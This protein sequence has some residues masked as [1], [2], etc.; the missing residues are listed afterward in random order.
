MALG[1]VAVVKA[2][3][4]CAQPGAALHLVVAA[5]NKATHLASHHHLPLRVGNELFGIIQMNK[6]QESESLAR[7]VWAT[8]R[9][10]ASGILQVVGPSLQK[11]LE[12]GIGSVLW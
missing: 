1:S 8:M 12:I 4:R 6:R 2:L 11:V 5:V 3:A 10:G 9:D 7:S